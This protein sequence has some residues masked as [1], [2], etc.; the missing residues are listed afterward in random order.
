M[1]PDPSARPGR[2]RPPASE[3]FPKLGRSV[4]QPRNVA[5][6]PSTKATIRW[7]LGG[8]FQLAPKRNLPVSGRHRHGSGSRVSRGKHAA[9]IFRYQQLGCR[10]HVRPFEK[11]AQISLG[12]TP[13]LPV[14]TQTSSCRVVRPTAGWPRPTRRRGGQLGFIAAASAAFGATRAIHQWLLVGESSRT[15]A[16]IREVTNLDPRPM[17]AL[18]REVR[19]L[20]RKSCEPD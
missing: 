19:R 9:R 1:G 16:K 13:A 15:A 6:A 3:I 5:T 17:S 18:P 10:A 8:R 20:P 14:P 12:R 4:E 11:A 7:S 2:R